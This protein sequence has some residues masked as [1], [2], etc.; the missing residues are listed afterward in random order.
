MNV[1]AS[2]R[3]KKIDYG[4]YRAYKYKDGLCFKRYEIYK[5]EESDV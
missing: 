2:M 4:W 1:P 5:Q 3:E